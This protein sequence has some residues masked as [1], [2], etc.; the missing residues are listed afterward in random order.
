MLLA[1]GGAGGF[2][3][4][5]GGLGGGAPGGDYQSGIKEESRGARTSAGVS[6]NNG[7]PAVLG[8]ADAA[9]GLSP[10]NPRP[11]SGNAKW[12]CVTERVSPG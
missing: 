9:L 12:V 2:R 3:G 4:A 11:Q 10:R 1:A 8:A 5:G 7:G 6:N